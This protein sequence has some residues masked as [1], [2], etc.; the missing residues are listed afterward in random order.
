MNK[1]VDHAS[2]PRPPVPLFF[3]LTI[4]KRQPKKKATET[5]HEK[6]SLMKTSACKDGSLRNQPN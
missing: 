6:F 1:K 3:S 4:P 2:S 5:S